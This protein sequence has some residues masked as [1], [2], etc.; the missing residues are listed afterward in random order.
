MASTDPPASNGRSRKEDTSLFLPRVRGRLAL[1]N[2]LLRFA[3]VID[4]AREWKAPH[5]I[6]GRA[7]R[8]GIFPNRARVC[9]AYLFAR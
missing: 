6:E 8:V 1:V 9:S 2:F 7:N 5:E 4:G 3:S